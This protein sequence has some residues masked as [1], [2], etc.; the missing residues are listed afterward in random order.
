MRFWWRGFC[1]V[2]VLLLGLVACTPTPALQ[3]P[4]GPGASPQTA[5]VSPTPPAWVPRTATIVMN[6]DLLWHNTLVFD[7]Q[8]AGSSSKPDFRPLLEGVRAVVEPADL[9]ICHNEVPIGPPGGPY[10]YYPSFRVPQETLDAVKTIGYDLCTTASNHSLDDGW[11]GVVRTL[12]ALDARGLQHAGTARTEEE[13][14]HPAIFTTAGGVR[15]AVVA[16][17]YGTN[18]IPRPAGKPWA[19]ADLEA[20]TMLRRAATARAEGAEIVLA[21]MHAGEEYDHAPNDEQR[22]LAERLTASADIDLVYGH[23][24]HVVQPWTQLHGKWVVYGLGN[25][26]AQHQT[27]VPAAYEGV[28]AR[29]AFHETEPGRFT[30]V[31]AEYLPTLVTHSEAG[32]PARLYLVNQALDQGRGDQQRLRVAQDRTRR[33]VHSLGG[34]AGLMES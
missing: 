20:E 3:N 7:A 17:T 18:G 19:V 34:A 31:R 14:E 16:G 21:A 9:A 12:E 5:S 32:S 8:R 15:I 11:A 29:F 10:S 22:R 2:A 25:L 26:V 23:H 1:L 28:T 27:S 24:V 6:G 33:V 30:V 4:P 13:A